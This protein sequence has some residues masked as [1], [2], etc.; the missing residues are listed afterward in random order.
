M[1]QPESTSTQSRDYNGRLIGEFA[2]S[3]E[4]GININ[5]VAGL[6]LASDGFVVMQDA[7]GI[8]INPV[9]GLQPDPAAGAG[10]ALVAGININPVA[11]L[12]LATPPR[13]AP[14]P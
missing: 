3:T 6:Q 10:V 5:P 4:A 11:G 9:A 2:R 14:S 12:Q 1:G 7:A 13:P 8:N